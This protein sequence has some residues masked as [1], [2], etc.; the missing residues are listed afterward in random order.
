MTGLIRKISVFSLFVLFFCSTGEVQGTELLV[1]LKAEP[2]SPWIGQK[3]VLR[4]D[5]L[6]KDGWA[7]VKSFR[8]IE[9]DGGF[10]R[11][12]ET[13][14]TRLNETI[15]GTAYSG[16]RYEFLFFGLREG[17]FQLKSQP[18]EVE[19]KTW[20]TQSS[21]E[22]LQQQ[23]PPV[24]LQIR[25]PPDIPGKVPVVSS[26]RFRAE[27]TWEP[28][29][30][31]TLGAGDAV[32]RVIKRVG[33]DVSA[34]I[35]SPLNSPDISGVGVYAK[36]P[37]VNDS[38]NR[39]ELVGSRTE[40]ITYVMEQAGTYSLPEVTL[41]WWD[42]ENEKPGTITLPGREVTVEGEIAPVEAASPITQRST[43]YQY[44]IGGVFFVLLSLG[45]LKRKQIVSILRKWTVAYQ[46]SEK[47]YFTRIGKAAKAKDR[48][49]CI[50]AT[51]EWLDSLPG[52]TNPARLDL[53]L[54]SY[55]EETA[56]NTVSWFDVDDGSWSP[57][58][59]HQE[60]TRARKKYL[61]RRH[62]LSTAEAVLPPVGPGGGGEL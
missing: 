3:V 52:I 10:L 1:R 50:R 60:L 13:Q 42:L 11:R 22:I 61:K 43:L 25:K 16:Q 4:L 8:K 57:E 35:F 9:V 19:I 29:D 38:F 30:T 41:L 44:S 48:R 14:G 12:Y 6:A 28:D 20:G 36:E 51:M 47:A 46:H 5:V 7:Q 55:G 56:G 34:M 37:V 40:S 33:D 59:F 27:Q 2:E 53:F 32:T 18:L 23:T 45:Y 54:A 49:A 31:D 15:D 17:E 62:Q 26:N 39:G 58:S 21:S 24:S